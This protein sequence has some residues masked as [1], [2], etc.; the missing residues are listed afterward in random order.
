MWSAGCGAAIGI[1]VDD[2]EA[3]LWHRSSQHSGNPALKTTTPHGAGS[4]HGGGLTDGL[5]LLTTDRRLA[6]PGG[7]HALQHLMWVE[8]K[9]EITSGFLQIQAHRIN[10]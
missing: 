6:T 4:R 10:H 8:M 3:T 5:E 2:S 1:P 7:S 9:K